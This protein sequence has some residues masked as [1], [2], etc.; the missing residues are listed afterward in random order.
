MCGLSA[1][2]VI[3]QLTYR[4]SQQM[5]S[6]NRHTSNKHPIRSRQNSVFRTSSGPVE[7]SFVRRAQSKSRLVSLRHHSSVWLTPAILLLLALLPW[8]YGYYSFL[9]LGV[10]AV[11]AWLAY[12]QLKHDSAVS[13]WVVAFA[14]TALL[15]NPLVPIHLT[16]EIWS[17]LNLASA[18]LFVGH[19]WVLRQ[20]L[21]T[22]PDDPAIVG[23]RLSKSSSCS[24][25]HESAQTLQSEDSRSGTH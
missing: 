24:L 12:E 3:S 5:S 8:P 20:M 19:F 2:V 25:T 11:S 6:S 13:G 7:D 23:R 14:G 18:G 21:K 17:V 4:T 10:C 16:R 15:Y 1:L 22:I 9:R